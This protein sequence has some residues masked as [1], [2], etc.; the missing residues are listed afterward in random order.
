MQRSK[1]QSFRKPVEIMVHN[2]KR[3]LTFED[4]SGNAGARGLLHQPI[5]FL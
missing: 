3:G 1:S 4:S 2:K 5:V